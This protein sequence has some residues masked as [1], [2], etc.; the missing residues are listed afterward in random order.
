M[1]A[2]IA[3]QRPRKAVPAAADPAWSRSRSQRMAAYPQRSADTSIGDTSGGRGAGQGAPQRA[4]GDDSS[5]PLQF[6][7]TLAAA[8]DKAAEP[9]KQPLPRP[10]PMLALA[11]WRQ[12]CVP[13]SR[14]RQQAALAEST[15]RR[16]RRAED[17][18]CACAR[19]SGARAG[20]AKAAGAPVMAAVCYVQRDGSRVPSF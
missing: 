6:D 4:L 10:R 9:K 7:P 18:A 1:I 19:Q 17:R 14:R 11:P 12:A 20:Q 15:G 8:D 5:G 16:Q 2:I 3:A 13:L